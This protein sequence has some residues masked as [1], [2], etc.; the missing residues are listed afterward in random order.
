MQFNIDSWHAWAPG[1]Q[2]HEQWAQWHPDQGLDASQGQPD[3]SFLPAMQR[4]RLSRMA[5]MAFSVA[6]PLAEDQAPMPLVFASRH[7]E[8]PRNLELLSDLARD[9]ALSPTQFSLSVHNAIIGLWSIMRGDTSEMTA[10]AAQADGLEHAVMEACCLLAEGAPQVLLIITEDEQPELYRPWID[11]APFP[12]ALALRLSPGSDWTLELTPSLEHTPSPLPH[13]INLVQCLSQG[14]P[15][16]RHNCGGRQWS[17]H[18][19]H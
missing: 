17:W 1:I 3:V 4:R 14:W 5:R 8:T 13:A 10:I 11:D 7:G 6:W 18:A 12:Y 9:Q 19:P 15:S 16:L 2:T